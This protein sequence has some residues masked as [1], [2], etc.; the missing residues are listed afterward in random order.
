[1]I[2]NR[3]RFMQPFEVDSKYNMVEVQA[4]FEVN[5]KHLLIIDSDEKVIEKTKPIVDSWNSLQGKNSLGIHVKHLSNLLRESSPL[6]IYKDGQTTE[7]KKDFNVKDYLNHYSNYHSE[8]K[9]KN[10]TVD[11]PN[12]HQ[13]L[14]GVIYFNGL[15]QGKNQPSDLDGII[16]EGNK[17]IIIELKYGDKPLSFGQKLLLQRLCD[18]WKGE[19]YLLHTTHRVKDPSQTVTQED[20]KVIGIYHNYNWTDSN[21]KLSNTLDSILK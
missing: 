7:I 16:I 17:L 6:N 14:K 1:M 5:N 20:C 19:A 8:P 15:G 13:G 11:G 21:N 3:E 12:P 9:L 2:K 4:A 10:T 18:N